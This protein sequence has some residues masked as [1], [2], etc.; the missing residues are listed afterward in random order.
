MTFR[1]TPLTGPVQGVMLSPETPSGLG[2]VVLGGS[3]GKIDPDRAALF[4][5]RG[6]V[7]IA[8]R[9]FGGEG[10]SPGICEIPLET[11]GAAIDRLA[12]EGCNRIA[13]I[14]TS[15]GAEAALL[16]AAHDPRV[17]VVIAV[18]PSS[19]VW[20]NSGPGSDGF[21][22]PPRSG[23]SYRGKPL[24]FVPHEAEA[25]L[26]VSQLPPIPYLALHRASL[27][28]FADRLDDA[29]IPI[30][31]ARAKVILVAG[32]DD[33]LWPS[34]DFAR[35]LADRLAAHGKAGV[36]VTHQ[37]AGHRVLLPGETT[38]RSA[39]NAHGGGDEP[40]AELG[41]MAWGEIERALGF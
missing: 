25:L 21:G 8:Q 35:A 5:S 19:V 30:E 2:V 14:G 41:R 4:A 39:L 40:D 13:L 31:Q 22:W 15:K 6:A 33:A 36:L 16:V 38:P 27:A 18:S 26:S 17:D 12:A 11:F 3:S 34:A 29:A 23:F 32:E 10:Q 1:E 9:W 20:A 7:A 37:Q 24:A 28:T